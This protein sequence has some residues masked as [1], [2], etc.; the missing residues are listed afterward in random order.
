MS[1]LLR[2]LLFFL[3]DADRYHSD[4][5]STSSTVFFVCNAISHK[6]GE[7]AQILFTKEGLDDQG[8]KDTCNLKK[9]Y[10]QGE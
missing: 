1:V 2:L 9:K 10:L 7:C 5:K 8:R 6:R 4:H 3:Q